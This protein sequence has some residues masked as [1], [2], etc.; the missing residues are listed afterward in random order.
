LFNTLNTISS[1]VYEDPRKADAMLARLAGLLRKTLSCSNTQVVP[2]DREV[3]TLELYLE[4]MRLRFENKLEVDVHLAPEVHKA[5][6][7]HLL[8]QPLVENAIRHGGD[9]RS[10]A[11]AI[12]ITAERDGGNTRVR[13]RDWGSGLSKGGIHRGTGISN[14]AERLQQLYGARHKLEFENCADGGL[15]V[16]V[17]FPY[18]T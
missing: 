17:A 8:L 7:P 4:I 1:V 11:V 9:P 2:L 5:L 14:T 18:Q 15:A 6:A 16:T 12:Q 3:E 13:V 10:H